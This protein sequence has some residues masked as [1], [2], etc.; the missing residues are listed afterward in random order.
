MTFFLSIS[1]AHALTWSV[2]SQQEL[3]DALD[4]RQSGDTIRIVGDLDL[5]V[6][7]NTSIANLLTI[8]A[9]GTASLTSELAGTPV[10]TVANGGD[11]TLR[12][13]TVQANT[14]GGRALVV[15]VGSLALDGVS[16]VGS[17]V[18]GGTGGGGCILATDAAL[19]VVGSVVQ[20]CLSNGDGGA[21]RATNTTLFMVS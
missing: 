10:L 9:V 18:T 14:S 5:V 11:L 8:E 2:L 20:G 12:D 6:P 15:T 16:V 17:P 7:V 19:S 4:G 1:P 13:L 3:V 21:I